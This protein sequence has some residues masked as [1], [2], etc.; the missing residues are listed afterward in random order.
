M[1]TTTHILLLGAGKSS[2]VKQMAMYFGHTNQFQFYTDPQAF[3]LFDVCAYM[4]YDKYRIYK[5]PVYSLTQIRHTQWPIGQ[6]G[7][8]A[9]LA[10]THPMELLCVT[11]RGASPPAPPARIVFFFPINSG[12]LSGKM[13]PKWARLSS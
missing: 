9:A 6:V 8:L 3:F 11:S 1:E 5:R 10:P 4:T 7:E 12:K 13:T 2:L